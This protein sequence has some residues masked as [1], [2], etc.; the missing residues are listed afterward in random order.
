MRRSIMLRLAPL[1]PFAIGACLW[2]GAAHATNILE[3]PDNGSEQMGRGGAWVARASDPLAVAFNPA[4]LAGQDTRLTL[5]SNFNFGHTCFT[6]VKAANDLTTNDGVTYTAGQPNTYP[7]VC[8]KASGTAN[9]QLAFAYK[10][11][12]RLTAGIAILG[13]S[14]AGQA[15]WPE[16]SSANG[17]NIPGPERYLLL[18]TNVV[19]LEPTIGI[20]WEVVDRVRIGAAFIFGTAPTI[21]FANASAATNQSADPAMNDVR[22]ELTA[23]K[24]FIPGFNTGVLWSPTNNL[25]VSGFYKYMSPITASGAD[26]HAYSYYF[27]KQVAN[28]DTGSPTQSGL[29]SGVGTIRVPIPME[30]KLGLRYHQPRN[31]A[32]YNEHRR[33][34]MAQDA[35][36][37]EVDG[38]WAHDSQFQAID[39]AFPTTPSLGAIGIPG[40][41]PPTASVP[42]NFQ[43]VFG[44]RA[45]GDFS[46]LPD[47]LSV[48]AGA[49]YET[50]A[51]RSSEYQNIDFMAEWRLGLAAGGTYRLHYGSAEHRHPIDL[52]AGYEHMFVGTSTNLSQNCI[53]AI[54]GDASAPQYRTAWPINLGTITNSVNVINV[55]ASI[56]F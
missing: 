30:A 28:G 46:I 16:F 15:Q 38:T 33:D 23:S 21:D 8:N 32:T 36:D 22:A 3:F 9:P 10:I 43:D 17:A 4:G 19:L 42:H 55:G 52:M 26:L 54:S 41:L 35:W 53:P 37:V 49:F 24:G 11:N 31:A 29:Y 44:L 48:R 40:N 34:P 14:A 18:R 56:A 39:I 6:R 13:P 50:P 27:T 2:S 25:D 5:Q 7:Q 20:G 12:D 51:Q 45:G 47:Q 1:A